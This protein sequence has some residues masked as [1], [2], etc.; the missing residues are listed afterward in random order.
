MTILSHIMPSLTSRKHY[1]LLLFLLLMLCSSNAYGQNDSIRIG[2]IEF[3]GAAGVNL[4]QLRAALPFRE[5]DMISH[6]T[7]AQKTEEARRAIER[8]AGRAPTDI[9]KT[10]CDEHRDLIIFI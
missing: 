7:G 1:L 10:C 4:E 6:E 5:G 3:Y 8:V 9:Q 2:E